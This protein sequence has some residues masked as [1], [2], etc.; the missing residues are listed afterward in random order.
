MRGL[1]RAWARRWGAPS[2]GER[3]PRRPIE[4]WD[5]PTD[6]KADQTGPG[7]GPGV[8]VCPTQTG[9]GFQLP[10]WVHSVMLLP[11][12]C[13]AFSMAPEVPFMIPRPPPFLP[14]PHVQPASASELELESRIKILS[15]ENRRL[16]E[17]G[18]QMAVAAL[19]VATEY[20]GIHRLM[21]AVSVWAKAMADE[22]G[23]GEAPELKSE[24]AR[25]LYEVAREAAGEPAAVEGSVQS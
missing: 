18:A 9:Y 1:A 23:R 8:S 20:D 24:T 14:I 15:E 17:A 4:G 11:V 5:R 3:Q 25:L 6:R 10:H 2:E 21:L 7:V 19:R 12:Q 22:N 16:R 13:S